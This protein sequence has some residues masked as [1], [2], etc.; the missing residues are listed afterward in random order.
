MGASRGVVFNKYDCKDM[1]FC[2]SF[3]VRSYPAIYHYKS[4]V[5]FDV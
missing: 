5:D 4:E 1:V 2:F 3:F